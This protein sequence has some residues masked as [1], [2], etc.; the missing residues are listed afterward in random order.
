MATG[1]DDV[2][3]TEGEAQL[4][5][6]V[7]VKKEAS[8]RSVRIERLMQK[9]EMLFQGEQLA[10]LRSKIRE[11]L[12]VP[13]WGEHHD[14]GM[15]MD[16][17]LALIL[18]NKE[19]AKTDEF[20]AQIPEEMRTLLQEVVKKYDEI[21]EKYAFLHDIAKKDC[22]TI[23]YEDGTEKAITWEEWQGMLPPALR[24]NPDPVQFAAFAR[25]AKIKQISYYQKEEKTGK[26]VTRPARK[27]G[28]VGAEEARSVEGLNI[29]PAVITAIENHEVAYQF[30]FAN[31]K[32]YEKYFGQM[33][34]EERRLALTGSYL[35]TV[36][37]LKSSGNPDL[38]NFLA[39]EASKHNFDIHAAAKADAEIAR[40]QSESIL[41]GDKIKKMMD[42]VYNN[43]ERVQ[44]SAEELIGRIKDE[45]KPTQYDVGV[46]AEKLALLV[47]A[48]T[49][50]ELQKTRIVE[51]VSTGR[52]KS[53]GNEFG[54]VL[55]KNM[56]VVKG[57]LQESEVR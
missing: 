26:E 15:Y 4:P 37:A 34:D 11:S 56:N 40:L 42:D 46:L 35:D 48:G 43:R 28:S 52:V 3:A 12:Q 31:A 53:I 13:Q 8:E 30:T 55:G 17:H 44:L 5:L 23:K 21:L 19:R 6:E 9:V 57:A 50:S 39:L 36:S 20:S 27:H 29:P 45:C 32:T 16:S 47:T 51:L 22:L 41:D 38:T 24:E 49:L 10:G 18:E 54:K 14:E 2:V 33:S 1:R 25:Q 7:R